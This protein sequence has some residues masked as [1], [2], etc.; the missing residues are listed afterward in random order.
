MDTT[1]PE[2]AQLFTPKPVPS[3]RR[4]LFPD[5]RGNDSV[6]LPRGCT[7]FAVWHGFCGGFR[8]NERECRWRM[9]PVAVEGSRC[10]DPSTAL[11]RR[12]DLCRS[13][14]LLSRKP[15]RHAFCVRH[16]VCKH[17]IFREL[18]NR[19][20]SCRCKKRAAC[21]KPC[22]T[23]VIG[24]RLSGKSLR[25]ME[26][27]LNERGCRIPRRMRKGCG[28]MWAGRCRCG[29]TRTGNKVKDEEFGEWMESNVC[30]YW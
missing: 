9:R 6:P 18:S 27:R 16:E 10:Q 17:L 5:I 4:R 22:Q 8:E 7:R 20:P 30:G 29:R 13:T 21:R 26:G 11:R 15:A 14:V 19:K 3:I 2:I 1:I 24:V 12:A 23:A 28:R 25:R